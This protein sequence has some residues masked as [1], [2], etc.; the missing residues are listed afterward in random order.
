[1]RS[2][3]YIF[4]LIS[5]FNLSFSTA[6][7]QLFSLSTDD[8]LSHSANTSCQGV[9]LD[10]SGDIYLAGFT[11]SADFPRRNAFQ[12]RWPGGINAFVAKF[13][14]SGSRLLYSTYLGGS[15]TDKAHGII[16]DSSQCAVVA[17]MT[18]SSDYPCRNAYQ[19]KRAGKLD[20]FITRLDS[21]GSTLIYSTYL[22]GSLDDAAFDIDLDSSGSA[23]L[24]GETISWDFP[25]L[26][27]YQASKT[28]W[29]QD[30]FIA[31]LTTCGTDLVYSTY[32]GGDGVDF[33]GKIGI[34]EDSNAYVGGT[35]WSDNFPTR[36]CYS[37]AKSGK[38]DAFVSKLTSSGNDLIY[39]TYLGGQGFD[40]GNDIA[41]DKTGVAYITGFTLGEGFPESKP[42]YKR[43]DEDGTAFLASLS[44]SGSSLPFSTCWGTPGGEYG[45]V[46]AVDQ[47]GSVYLSGV[48]G[49]PD[50]PLRNPFQ[51]GKSG[52]QDIFMVKIAFP[53]PDIIYSTYLGGLDYERPFGL[54]VNSTGC[55]YLA[56]CTYSY[57]FPVKSA[58]QRGLIGGS[59]GFIT[60]FNSSGS[61]L[62]FSTFLG[63]VKSR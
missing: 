50:F 22:G 31:R 42:L 28:G 3:R 23:Y 1:M 20:A 56:G 30:V 25:T 52:R 39:S 4:I 33:G 49:S 37:P 40:F 48:T 58:Y 8:Y 16:V 59:A 24:S 6:S 13:S 26:N 12:A 51:S 14:S 15:G 45:M 38:Y 5:G 41:V 7:A 55:S 36:N 62:I 60:E 19:S 27:A 63:G 10:D 61:S 54:T 34:D 2:I 21:S 32:L 35:T 29:E 9:V 53:G 57:N 18:N 46:L 44:P 43:R 47:L 17:G 11:H